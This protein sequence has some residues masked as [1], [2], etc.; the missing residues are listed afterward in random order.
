MKKAIFAVL[1]VLIIAVAGIVYYVFANLDA[2][3]KAAIEKYGSQA[4]QTQV[5]VDDV[6]IRLTEGTGTIRGLT[7][8]NP[9][10]FSLPNAFSLGEI[11]TTINLDKTSQDLIVIDLVNIEAPEV[12]YEINADRQGSLNVLKD[13][14]ATGKSTSAGPSATQQ[15]TGTPLKLDI[16][17]FQLQDAALQAKIVPLKNKMYDLTLPPLTLTGLRGTPQQISKQ[18]MNQLVD[19]AQTAI[20]KKGLDKELEELKARAKQKLD[21]RKAELKEKADTKLDEEKDQVKDKLEGLL[22]R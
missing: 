6:K 1:I 21:E 5:R 3:V 15:Q 20:R 22:N 13:N 7:V 16:A 17:R 11:T 18:V 2:I 12:F 14:L 4:I 8:A 19:H 10:G 9:K